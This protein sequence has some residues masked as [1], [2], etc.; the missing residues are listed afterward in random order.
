MSRRAVEKEPEEQM[1]NCCRQNS[2]EE[3][4]EKADR[5][6]TGLARL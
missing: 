4:P 5:F 6:I 1:T 3:L 2:S